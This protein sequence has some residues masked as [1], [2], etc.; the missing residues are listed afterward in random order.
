MCYWVLRTFPKARQKDLYSTFPGGGLAMTSQWGS[1]GSWYGKSN[2]RSYWATWLEGVASGTLKNDF[3]GFGKRAA[4]RTVCSYLPFRTFF[5]S[6]QKLLLPQ[7]SISCR[8][9]CSRDRTVN[10]IYNFLFN[11]RPSSLTLWVRILIMARC[12]GYNIMWQVC[13]YICVCDRR[14]SSTGTYTILHNYENEVTYKCMK[15]KKCIKYDM[16]SY[17]KQQ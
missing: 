9:C 3:V 6:S 16:A 8:G 15:Y 2:H 11:Q 5:S 13:K 7:L 12:T 14:D 1:V 17:Y 10:W 4:K